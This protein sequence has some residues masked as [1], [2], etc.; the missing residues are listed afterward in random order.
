M[1]TDAEKLLW[2]I[3]GPLPDGEL[4]L[5]GSVAFKHSSC[6]FVMD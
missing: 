6:K 4:V 2:E 3:F 5:R 1:Q